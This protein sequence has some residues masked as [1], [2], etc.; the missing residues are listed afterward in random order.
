MLPSSPSLDSACIGTLDL[1]DMLHGLC[2]GI[3]SQIADHNVCTLISHLWNEL[4][5][6]DVFGFELLE[7]SKCTVGKHTQFYHGLIEYDASVV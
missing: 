3:H 4:S 7:T 2:D 6:Y 1:H 5:L